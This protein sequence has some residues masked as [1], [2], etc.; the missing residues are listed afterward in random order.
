METI[1]KHTLIPRLQIGDQRYDY[2]ANADDLSDEAREFYIKNCEEYEK[3][4]PW[5]KKLKDVPHFRLD[6]PEFDTNRAIAEVNEHINGNFIPINMK[7]TDETVTDGAPDEHHS[8]GARALIN[9]TPHSDRWFNKQSKECATRAYPEYQPYASEIIDTAPRLNLDDMKYY[10]TELWDRMSYISGFLRENICNES[11]RSFIWKIK[12]HGYLNWHNHAKL[13]WHTDLITND[14]AIVHIPLITNEQIRML[15]EVHGKIYAQYY[16][17][18]EAWIFNNIHDHAVENKSSID[19][20]HV[21]MF[22]PWHDEKFQKL[23]ERSYEK[24]GN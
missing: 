5:S 14:K 9:Y 15:V 1:E 11:Y 2:S 22:V 7:T 24:Y 3:K 13:P 12:G 18:G 6:I 4:A 10:E 19:R 20:L 17:P 16:P 23:L 21:A 8:W